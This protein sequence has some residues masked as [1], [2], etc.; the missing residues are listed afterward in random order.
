MSREAPQDLIAANVRIIEDMRSLGLPSLSLLAVLA[1][2]LASSQA[3]A[4]LIDPAEEACSK[5]GEACTVDGRDGVCKAETCSKLDYSNPGPSGSPGTRSYDCVRC[6]I[7]AKA[8]P[9]A[10]TE[11]TPSKGAESPP[12]PDKAASKAAP[13][14]S[15]K[16]Q[17][18]GKGC[19]VEPATTSMLSFALGLGLLGLAV[20]RRR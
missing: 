19:S 5:A 11:P 9:P 6:A 2:G 16:P 15:P 3:R 12:T 20:R 17:A 7:G 18:K 4:D 13:D 1:G 8:E 10:P 14:A